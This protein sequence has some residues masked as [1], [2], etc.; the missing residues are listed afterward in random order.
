WSRL[1]R[2]CATA[3]DLARVSEN[4]SHF[5][6]SMTDPVLPAGAVAVLTGDDPEAVVLA[7]L[8]G[9]PVRFLP[10]RKTTC[11]LGGRAHQRAHTPADVISSA[12][13]PQAMVL[14]SL[15]PDPGQGWSDIADAR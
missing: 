6:T 15:S 13:V 7:A 5:V 3:H 14:S 10:G 1:I 12:H 9:S 8:A 11:H 2:S 4:F